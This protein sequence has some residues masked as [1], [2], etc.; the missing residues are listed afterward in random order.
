MTLGLSIL[1]APHHVLLVVPVP[2]IP[3]TPVACPCWQVRAVRMG[4]LEVVGLVLSADLDEQPG[5]R[6][7]VHHGEKSGVEGTSV[8]VEAAGKLCGQLLKEPGVKGG[9]AQPQ[10]PEPATGILSDPFY[11]SAVNLLHAAQK[12]PVQPISSSPAPTQTH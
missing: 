9:L 5:G 4:F 3:Q 10:G 7:T 6:L 11:V 2:N 12:I 8:A 1:S